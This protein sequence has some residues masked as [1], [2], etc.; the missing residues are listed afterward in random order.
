MRREQTKAIKA[1]MKM[2]VSIEK[3]KIETKKKIV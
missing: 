1:V 3:R 2:K